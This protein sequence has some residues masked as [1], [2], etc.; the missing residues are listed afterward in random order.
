MSG[1]YVGLDVSKDR[2][3][4]AVL[5]GQETWSCASDDVSLAGL[6]VRLQALLPALLVVEATGGLERTL[7]AAMG[8][9]GLPI[10]VVN[11]R[12]VRDFAKALG[13]LAKTDRI[14][15]RMLA[16]FAERVQ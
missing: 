16:L 8:A 12:Q 6:V 4:V 2:F 13:Q 7:V 9:A 10:V 1:I 5:P 15:A 14:D 11:P 3:D